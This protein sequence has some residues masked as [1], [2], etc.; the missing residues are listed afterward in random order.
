M[1][2]R[3]GMLLSIQDVGISD[4]HVDD[5]ESKLLPPLDRLSCYRVF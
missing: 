1:A 3:M 4:C 2:E 5:V